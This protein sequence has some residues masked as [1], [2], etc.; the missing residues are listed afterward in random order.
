MR[1]AAAGLVTLLLGAAALAEPPASWTEHGKISTVRLLEVTRATGAAPKLSLDGASDGVQLA[2]LIL[3]R[4]G[5]PGK[6]RLSELRDVKLGGRSYHDATKKTLGREFEPETQLYDVDRFLAERGD[7]RAAVGTVPADARAVV[8]V[9][10][11]GGADLPAKGKGRVAI[12][13]GWGES[14]EHFEFEFDLKTLSVSA[15]HDA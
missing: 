3:S 14:T 6:F 5:E 8:M 12:D 2:F 7:L 15:K 11:I 4:P 9:T 1:V 10:A 13:V